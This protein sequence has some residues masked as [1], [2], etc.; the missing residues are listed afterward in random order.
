[1]EAFRRRRVEKTAWVK[2]DALGFE[3]CLKYLPRSGMR[4]MIDKA[5]ETKWGRSGQ[6]QERINPDILL[7]ELAN[8][9]VNWRGLTREVYAR[10]IPIDPADYPEEIPCT[11]EYKR[12]LLAEAYGLDNVIREICT[13]LAR[14]QDQQLEAEIKN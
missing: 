13:D 6:P 11:D 4:D 5:T 12:E 14:F 3:M 8:Y 2:I 10:L 9:I 1:M 7:A